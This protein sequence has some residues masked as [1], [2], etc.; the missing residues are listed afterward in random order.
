MPARISFN[1]NRSSASM[2]LA[3]VIAFATS[4]GV[5]LTLGSGEASRSCFSMDLARESMDPDL[6]KR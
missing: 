4:L 5:I 2:D 3:T 1:P 6:V